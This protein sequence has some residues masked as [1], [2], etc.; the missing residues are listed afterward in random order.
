MENN[1]TRELITRTKL[2]REISMKSGVTMKDIRAVLD[3][4]ND[5]LMAHLGEATDDKTVRVNALADVSFHSYITKPT[6]RRNP[7]TGEKIDVPAK[8]TFKAKI[9]KA[10]IKRTVAN[11]D[12]VNE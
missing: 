4:A 5:I 11:D 9:P 12:A 2:I 8:L 7:Q 3:T 1:N 6:V 10:A